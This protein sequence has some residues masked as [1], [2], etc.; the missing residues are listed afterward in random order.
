[1][2]IRIAVVGIGAMGSGIVRTLLKAND[3][4][5]VAVAD[6]NPK[7]QE[8]IQPILSARTLITTEASEILKKKPDIL[9][10]ATPAI[11]ESAILITQALEQKI[12]VI[13]MNSE[14][15]QLLGQ[16]LAKKAKENG[17][18]LTSDA[19]DQYGVLARMIEDLE[20]M[21]FEIVMAGNNKGFLNRYATPSSLENEA[22]IRR[23][24]LNQCTAYTDGTKLAIE[25]AII[26][27]AKN[28]GLL[29]KHMMGPRIDDLCDALSA[30]DLEAARKTG[31]V[32]D[33]VL[34]A[35][36]GGSVFAIGYLKD[37]EDQFY[38]NYYKMGKGPYYL[39]IRPYHLCSFETPIA[40][41]SIVESNKPILI[42][43]RRILEV[44]A[45]AKT[46]IKSGTKLDGIGGYC[47]YGM[48]EKPGGLPI[49]LSD[50]AIVLKD[51]KKD[52]PI[53][54]EDVKIPE[55]DPLLALWQEQNLEN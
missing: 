18:I 48:L 21:G 13:L 44:C 29:G 15:D 1:V 45:Y 28:L 27:N 25:M 30:F 34:G 26:G 41:R 39:F 52:E 12:N 24:S 2:P 31:G 35:R 33:Y 23:L 10:D 36:P 37:P 6:K 20:L 47:L 54:W 7:A 51:K 46:D 32:V 17:V 8:R 49:G 19:G 16:S 53:K 4:E 50:R 5:I 43:S 9:I 40:I 14:V 38:M 3:I 55:K 22:A 42:Q 11:L